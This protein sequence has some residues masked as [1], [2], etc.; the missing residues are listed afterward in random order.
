MTNVT[1]FDRFARLRSTQGNDILI[2]YKTTFDHTKTNVVVSDIKFTVT[3]YNNITE[4]TPVFVVLI[5]NYYL[6][7][8]TK[9]SHQA[10]VI[11]LALSTVSL[12]YNF[13]AGISNTFTVARPIGIHSSVDLPQIAVSVDGI[14]QDDP[15]QNNQHN[16]NFVW[17]YY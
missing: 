1:T 12:G 3:V 7:Y 17:E 5:N 11:P 16:F 2:T 13:S 15:I 14:W 10:L 9:E 8:I 6:D 4:S